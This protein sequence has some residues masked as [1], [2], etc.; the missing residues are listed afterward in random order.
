METSQPWVLALALVPVLAL[1]LGLAL[2]S[3]LALVLGQALVPGLVWHRPSRP[4][5]RLA[6]R[7][8]KRTISSSICLPPVF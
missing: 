5:S 4:G 7:L 8:P 1:A 3:V 6:L 2:V